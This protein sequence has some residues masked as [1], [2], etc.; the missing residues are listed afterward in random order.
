M[1]PS[2][3]NDRTIPINSRLYDDR[4]SAAVLYPTDVV[5]HVV[6]IDSRFR[7][8]PGA[9]LPTDFTI[10]MPR[11]YKNATSV[12]LASIEIPN[13]WYEFSEVK[14]NI[15]FSVTYNANKQTITIPEGN[16]TDIDTLC[17][18]VQN[19]MN[20]A[21]SFPVTAQDQA[22][23]P[24]VMWFTVANDPLNS[25]V[26]IA[27][28]NGDSFTLTFPKNPARIYDT[29]FGYNLG[30]KDE[31]YFFRP[32]FTAEMPSDI[33]GP[34]YILLHIDDYE[35]VETL[36]YNDT[37]NTAFA[38]IMIQVPKNDVI[39]DT[40][41][42]AVSKIIRFPQPQNVATLRIR[43]TDSYGV[44]INTQTN[45]S[46]TLEITEIVNSRLYETQRQRIP[47]S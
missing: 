14:N 24:S 27:S 39:Y 28:N 31:T 46:F 18:T 43:F 7:T 9:T 1:L 33:I 4:T 25:R 8:N 44:T 2:G 41:Q 47:T 26:T 6:N 42:N 16:Y 36:T 13:V 35:C 19:I 23:D 5:T 34:N 37:T 11:P 12:R 15:T 40:G 22:V 38:K 20:D 29:G 21:Y 45:L 32:S 10:K 30:F 3:R 17:T